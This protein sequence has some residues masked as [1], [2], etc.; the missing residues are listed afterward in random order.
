MRPNKSKSKRRKT[1]ISIESLD[2]RV[3]LSIFV[4]T[5]PTPAPAPSP[6]NAAMVRRFEQ[7]IERVDRMF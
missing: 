6:F 5:P 4:P 1:E 7:R 2:D 3:M